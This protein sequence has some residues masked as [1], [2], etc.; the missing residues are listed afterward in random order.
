MNMKVIHAVV[1]H[2]VY[3]CGYTLPQ[4]GMIKHILMDVAPSG[5]VT[6]G[7]VRLCHDY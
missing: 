1:T 7:E 6:V 2:H 3:L 4:S 5:S